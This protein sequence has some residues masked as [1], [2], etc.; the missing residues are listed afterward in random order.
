MVFV[1]V[2]IIDAVFIKPVNV[3]EFNNVSVTV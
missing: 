2:I 3:I 1:I